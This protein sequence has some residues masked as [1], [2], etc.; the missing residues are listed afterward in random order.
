MIERGVCRA[1]STF[2]EFKAEVFR[3]LRTD[4]I[5]FKNPN[6]E[7]KALLESDEVAK[8]IKK[9]YENNEPAHMTAWGIDLLY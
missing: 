3:V 1:N 4:Y 5:N 2:E 9:E 7:V 8:I 6:E